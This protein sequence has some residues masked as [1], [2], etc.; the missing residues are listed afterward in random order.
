MRTFFTL[1]AAAV[2]AAGC[3]MADSGK[4]ISK[5]QAKKFETGETTYQEVVDKL[6]KPTNVTTTIENKR[7]ATYSYEE[8]NQDAVNYIPVAGS[9]FGGSNKKKTAVTFLFDKNDVLLGT[10]R[11]K[12]RDDTDYGILNVG[13]S[14]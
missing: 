12:S 13:D 9:L 8:Y 5:S 1:A 11:S 3:T 2:L 10:Q 4:K 7:K 14:E 6:G